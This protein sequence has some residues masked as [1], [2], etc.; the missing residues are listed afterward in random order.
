MR[1]EK[2]V[3]LI[4]DDDL[5]YL[6]GIR[7]VLESAGY[8]V[9]E[10]TGAEEGL[11]L[12]KALAPDLVIVDLMMEEVDAGTKLVKELKTIGSDVPVYMHSVV[13]DHLSLSTD[14]ASLGLAGV[15]QKPIDNDRLLDIVGRE[16]GA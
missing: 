2:H 8:E 4:I 12:F 13:G 15:F 16:L 7:T 6:L 10:A 14:C 3:I 1:D 9:A 5:D 11:R